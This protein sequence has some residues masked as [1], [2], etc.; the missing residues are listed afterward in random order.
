[1]KKLDLAEK[2]STQAKVS[3]TEARKIV[4][5]ILDSVIEGLQSDGKV[6]LNGFGSFSVRKRAAREM[7]N[8][9]TGKIVRVDAGVNPSK[10]LKKALNSK[11][12][13]L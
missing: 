10:K 3:S 8:P 7:K 9:R 13:A 4:D 5:I 1:M 12:N 11:S 2:V 6:S